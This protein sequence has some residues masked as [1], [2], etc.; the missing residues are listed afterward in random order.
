MSKDA[1]D[2]V[3]KLASV[4]E[5]RKRASLVLDEA[6]ALCARLVQEENEAILAF[7]N[8]LKLHDVKDSHNYGHD[9][10]L[11]N[12]WSSVVLE[13]MRTPEFTYSDLNHE[14]A[15]SLSQEIESLE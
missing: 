5:K 6:K 11:I 9:S 7:M 2:I 3:A 10:R 4:T 13:L 12:F 14:D 8:C 15:E 1:A